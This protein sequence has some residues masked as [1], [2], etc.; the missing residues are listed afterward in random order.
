MEFGANRQECVRNILILPRIFYYDMTNKEILEAFGN[1]R[2]CVIGDVMIDEYI[3]GRVERMSP[4]AP[5][6]VVDVDSSEKRLGGAANVA[7]NC[8]SLGAAVTLASVIGDDN[9]GVVL[10]SLLEDQGIGTELLQASP[11]RRTTCKQRI[12]SK[13]RQMMRIDYETRQELV[14]EEEHP[15]IDQ[16]MRFL[17]VEKPDIVIIEDY[18]K[19]VLKANVLDK[20]LGHCKVL[21]L[22]VAVDP[23][24][25]NFFAYK[26]VTIFKPNLKEIRDAFG[27]D[28]SPDLDSLNAIH[29]KLLGQLNHRVS[30][31]TLS[32][33][34]VYV[35][36]GT[37][38]AIYPT[39]RRTIADVSGAGDTVIAVAALVYAAT[40]DMHRAARWSNLAGGIVCEV[41]GVVPV[42]ASELLAETLRHEV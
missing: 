38:A 30:F 9:N 21:G 11:Y 27:Q 35:N 28:I 31:I 19:G 13:E 4:E 15:F 25:D 6:P 5:V 37:S 40:G 39:F 22:P 12:I 34:G 26:G 16:V 33:K 36:D 24:K 3:F 18:N 17:Q 41:S 42:S 1:M 8:R 20:I 32:E 7:L 2:V 10:K 29:E 23:K 14:K